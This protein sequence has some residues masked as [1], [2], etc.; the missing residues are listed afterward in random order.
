MTQG[1][2][3]QSKILTELGTY[4]R[5]LSTQVNQCG[6]SQPIHYHWGLIRMSHQASNGVRVKERDWGD[7]CLTHLLGCFHSCQ[8]W[9]RVRE[10]MLGEYCWLLW[11]VLAGGWAT[12]LQFPMDW[13]KVLPGVGHSWAIWPQPWHLKHWE[14][15]GPFCWLCLLAYP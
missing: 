9:S 5:D 7:F 3:L 12:F 6:H 14:S 11:L 10:G 13:L 4:A 1:L 15:W 8:F 2:D